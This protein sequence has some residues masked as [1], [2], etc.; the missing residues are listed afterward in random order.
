M[1]ADSAGIQDLMCIEY[2]GTIKNVDRLIE[3][4]GG[5]E[6][7]AKTFRSENARLELR[8]RPSSTYCH[9]VF[10][11][12]VVTQHLLIKFKRKT[13]HYSD[14]SKE[15]S[16]TPQIVGYIGTT[17]IFDSLVDFQYLPMVKSSGNN[18]ESIIEKILP[19]NPLDPDA[20]DGKFDPE[21]PVFILPAIFSRFDS[22]LE[23]DYRDGPR[24]TELTNLT[25]KALKGRASRSVDAIAIN[26]ADVEVPSGPE[27]RSVA[28]L[29][30]LLQDKSAVEKIKKMYEERP[31]W[32]RS[33]LIYL[34]RVQLNATKLILPTIAFYYL[35][36]PFRNQWVKFGYDCR[37][38]KDSVKYQSLDFRM[39][40]TYK[41]F[42]LD[43]LMGRNRRSFY[44]YQLPLRKVDDATIRR[45]RS[46]IGMTDLNET[47]RA[48]AQEEAEKEEANMNDLAGSVYFK[49]GQIPTRRQCYFNLCDIDLPL[50][51]EILANP[52][53][54]DQPDEKDGWLE[55]GTMDRIRKA[56]I[57]E[58]EVALEG[59]M[60]ASTASGLGDVP[61]LP[62]TS[63][64]SSE[65][66]DED[67]S[68]SNDEEENED[69]DDDEDE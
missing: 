56:M 24:K 43:Q 22:P 18:Y 41:G 30:K 34:T 68:S 38:D 11:D 12:R 33:A 21:A 61:V 19:S 69:E 42:Q 1:D 9:G 26:W 2:P 8:L 58:L 35:D 57:K 6:T 60:A 50:V 63:V 17:Y 4:V 10:G 29:E 67:D 13:T 32:S 23:Y 66:A 59:L 20:E 44:Q 62:S 7:L 3:A 37:K 5:R 55:Q 25:D 40:T 47:I 52:P 27:E 36:G 31:M 28:K 49:R 46:S 64:V 54:K 48:E 16:I 14:G 15:V 51:Q 53:E 39:K 45:S 65:V